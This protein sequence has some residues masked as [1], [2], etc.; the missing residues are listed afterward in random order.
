MDRITGLMIYYY[1]VCQKKLWYH[2]RGLNLEKY[3]EDV[4]IG[5]I[6]DETSYA[7]ENKHLSIDDTINIDFLKEWRV[8]HDVKK[9]KSIEEASLW[10]MKYYIYYLLEKGVEIEKGIIDYP[11]LKERKEVLLSDLDKLELEETISNIKKINTLSIP[12]KKE[13]MKICYKCSYYEY[14]FC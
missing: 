12:P 13:K 14:C 2:L 10:Q 1:Y 3:N 4:L 5:K 11:L 7:N 6:I 8:L 9:S